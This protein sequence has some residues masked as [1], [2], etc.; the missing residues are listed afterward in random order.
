MIPAQLLRAY[1][2]LD[3]ISLNQLIIGNKNYSPSRKVAAFCHENVTVWDS[4]AICE[5][6]ADLYPEKNCWP[7]KLEDKALA[8]S[9]SNEMH[10]GCF[11]IR[12]MLPM[13]CRKKMVFSNVTDS[14]KSDIGRGCGKRL[15]EYNTIF[16]LAQ[17]LGSGGFR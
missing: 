7:L 4:L 15:Y 17:R 1:W 2:T 16:K 3:W 8:R 11:A 9:I 5:F 13:N 10:S 12:N 14:L 6:V